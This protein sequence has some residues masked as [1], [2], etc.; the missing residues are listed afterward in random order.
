MGQEPLKPEEIAQLPKI[1]L[2]T[3]EAHLVEVKGQF[4]GMTGASQ[5]DYMLLGT[6]CEQQGQSVFVKMVGPEKTVSAQ[7]DNFIAFCKS[8]KR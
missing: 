3:C 1:T 2:L 5:P 4:Q 6:L 7:R 8:L